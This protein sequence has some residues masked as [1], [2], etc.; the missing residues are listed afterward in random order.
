MSA[1]PTILVVAKAPVA[2]QAKTR[3]AATVGDEAAARIAAASLLDTLEVVESLGWP[4]VIAL[5]GDLD[6]AA[7]ADELAAACGRHRVIAQRG[8]SFAS[9]LTAAHHDADAGHGV[10]QIGMD[11]PQITVEILQTAAAALESHD[12]A[13]G[14]AEDGGWW[15]LA[16][17]SP[18]WSSCLATVTMSRHDTG[19]RTKEALVRGGARVAS[20]P[21]M[22][23][24]DV[25]KDSHSVASLIPH[26]RFA[27]EVARAADHE[28]IG[29][30]P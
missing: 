10:V 18:D 14:L 19:C 13:L 28:E 12:A 24:V 5:T 2:G 25:W 3:L 1:S 15:V 7:R 4:V 6:E 29:S 16:V 22:A 9:R 27:A 30:Q 17:R 26:S 20:V 21:V 23:D 11:T 8:E